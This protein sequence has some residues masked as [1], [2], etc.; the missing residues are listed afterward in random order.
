MTAED[1]ILCDYTRIVD[2]DT[3]VMYH[4]TKVSVVAQREI[5]F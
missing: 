5:A 2:K 4:C 3:K 1:Q